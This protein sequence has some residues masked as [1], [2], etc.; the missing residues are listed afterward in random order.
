MVPVHPTV[1]VGA[2]F[3][4]GRFSGSGDA[5]DPFWRA[6]FQPV[7]ISVTPLRVFGKR[8]WLE[9]LQIHGSALMILGDIRAS[10]FGGTGPLRESNE[11]VPHVE[12]AIDLGLLAEL[13]KR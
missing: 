4:F 10:D 6:L 9:F 13:W 3:G 11:I 7:R 1:R 2:G 5:F 8:D 12:I